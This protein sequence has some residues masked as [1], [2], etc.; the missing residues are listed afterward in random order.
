MEQFF[1]KM[2]TIPLPQKSDLNRL[3]EQRVVVLLC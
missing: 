2:V 3:G 1:G